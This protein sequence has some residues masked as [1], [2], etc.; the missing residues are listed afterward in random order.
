MKHLKKFETFEISEAIINPSKNI[1][2]ES[3]IKTFDN[4]VDYGNINGFD[5]VRFKEFYE[6][7]PENMKKDVPPRNTP[8][9]ALFHPTNRKPMFVLND[10]N[11]IRCVPS[12]IDI[13]DDIIAHER[14][15]EKQVERS[16]G[17]FSL[18]N[19]NNMREYFSD[20]NEIMAFSWSIANSIFNE[21]GTESLKNLNK[22]LKDYHSV[23]KEGRLW[24]DITRFV[25]IKT[26]R[27]YKK[28]IYLYLENIIEQEDN[29]S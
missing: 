2:I 18:P 14:V 4:L 13:I 26:N 22:I 11:F 7:L 8:F 20:K 28:Y 23:G 12:A 9:F 1:K 17:I 5:V 15:H 24:Q 6:S 16:G 3:K 29:I 10:D 25:D 27:R 19:P 21:N